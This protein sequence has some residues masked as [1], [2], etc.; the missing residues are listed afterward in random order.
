[1][2]LFSAIGTTETEGSNEYRRF[3]DS[4]KRILNPRQQKPGVRSQGIAGMRTHCPLENS[5]T[6]SSKPPSPVD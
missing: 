3:F 5:S 2:Q 1:M 4:H 6:S